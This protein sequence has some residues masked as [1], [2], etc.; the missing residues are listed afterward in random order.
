MSKSD[1]DLIA[2]AMSS[3]NALSGAVKQDTQKEE[4]KFT[5]DIPSDNPDLIE[6]TLLPSGFKSY[7]SGTKIFVRGMTLGEVKTLNKV[8][9][10]RTLDVLTKIYSKIISGIRVEDLLPVDFKAIMFFVAKLTDSEFT[11]ELTTNCPSCGSNFPTTVDFTGV[12][13]QEL[14]DPTKTVDEITYSPIRVLDT[15]FM[16][17]LS[18]SE[19]GQDELSR[20]DIEFT[21]LVLSRDQ[22]ISENRDLVKFYQ[23]YSEIANLPASESNKLSEIIDWLHLDINPFKLECRSCGH[24]FSSVAKIDFSKIYL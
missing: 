1:K 22:S 20:S 9:G 5:K 24:H 6:V 13:F 15:L 21:M 23:L 14:T 4:S 7:P 8:S 16:N 12:D 10:S 11:L 17:Q 3:L 19:S 18:A 2:D